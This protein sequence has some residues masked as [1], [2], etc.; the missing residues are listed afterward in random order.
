M[1]PADSFLVNFP[2]LADLAD[3]WMQAHCSIPDGFNVG[4]PFVMT[5]WQFWCTANHYRIRKTAKW[6]PKKPMMNQAFQFRRSQIVGPQK[7]GKGP[8][9]AAIVAFEAVGPCLYAGAAEA[10]DGFACSDHGCDC[11][12]EHEYEVGEPMGMP[13]PTPIIQMTATVEDQVDNV[14]GPLT[15]MI[16]NGPLGDRMQVREGFIRL[17]NPAKDSRID[18]VSSNARSRV[19]KRV[20][21]VLNDETGLYTKA[22]GLVSVAETQRRGAAGMQGRTMESTNAWDPSQYSYA[23]QSF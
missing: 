19:G 23:Q 22:N 12:F 3:P 16:E 10:G 4:D 9:S 13:Q 5:D 7:S 20:S 14:Y 15:T 11:G 8:W 21:F 6:Q 17:P 18:K 1:P 2:T